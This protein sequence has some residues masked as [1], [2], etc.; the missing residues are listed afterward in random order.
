MG[1]PVDRKLDTNHMCAL[2]A[3]KVNCVLG[4]IERSVDSRWKEVTLSLC[5]VLVRPHL[6]FHVKIWSPQHRRVMDLLECIQTRVAKVIRGMGCLSYENRL[7][8]PGLFSLWKALG[9]PDSCLSVSKKGETIRKK[10]RLFSR[11]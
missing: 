3:W 6:E 11:V 9:R 1:V 7:R 2:A 10:G 8:E 4:C 5:S